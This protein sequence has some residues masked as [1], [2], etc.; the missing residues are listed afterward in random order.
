MASLSLLAD[1]LQPTRSLSLSL[2]EGRARTRTWTRSNSSE[3]SHRSSAIVVV[4]VVVVCLLLAVKFAFVRER[5]LARKTAHCH[6]RL[7]FLPFR[8]ARSSPPLELFGGRRRR[9]RWWPHKHPLGRYRFGANNNNNGRA[10]L[11]IEAAASELALPIIS[12]VG[13]K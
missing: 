11:L 4:V 8:T 1:I 13:R 2:A 5:S 10:P 3:R 6:C 12:A 7:C 9:F